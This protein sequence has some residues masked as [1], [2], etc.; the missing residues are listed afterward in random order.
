[1]GQS[2]CDLIQSL[3]IFSFFFYLYNWN[4]IDQILLLIKMANHAAL[5]EETYLA[6]N[7]RKSHGGGNEMTADPVVEKESHSQSPGVHV[8]KK[9]EAGGLSLEITREDVFI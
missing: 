2:R 8:F 7:I 1:M 4:I 3:I 9:H 6:A 5:L